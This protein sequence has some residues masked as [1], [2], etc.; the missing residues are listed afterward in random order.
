MIAPLQVP[1]SSRTL[2]LWPGVAA[3]ALL[4]LARFGLKAVIPGFAG[5]ARGMI[6]GMI[7]AAAVVAWWLF[8]SRARWPE[9]V[10]A[11][12]LMIAALGATWLVK[13]ESM[14]PLW[15]IGYALPV[16]CLAFILTILIYRKNRAEVQ[17]WEIRWGIVGR[18]VGTAFGAAL[19]SVIAREYTAPLIAVLVL[20]AVGF[21]LAGRRLR[22]TIPNLVGVAAISGFMGTVASI[23]GPPLA[24]LYYDQTGGRIRGTLSGIFIVGSVVAVF[25]LT[26]IDRF[27]QAELLAA[28]A[29]TPAIFIGYFLSRSVSG[30][31]ERGYLKP[32]VLTVSAAASLFILGRYLF[33]G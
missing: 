20:I 28:L 24:L 32:A 8:F 31:L 9:R 29:M 21:T 2:R 25:S 3:V 17:G 23:G 22:V 14:G 27:G 18:I 33:A 11:L 19:L 12:V 5:F 7:G 13:H 6:G 30:F 16:L 10:G 15:L 4:W 1:N 26:L